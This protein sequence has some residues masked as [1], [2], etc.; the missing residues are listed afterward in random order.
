VTS[1]EDRHL[2]A[3]VEARD[4]PPRPAQDDDEGHERSIARGSAV[5]WGG[6]CLF[7]QLHPAVDRNHLGMTS[8]NNHRY[9]K[10]F[11]GNFWG[12]PRPPAAIR[13]LARSPKSAP[14]WRSAAVCGL[15]AFGGAG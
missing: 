2:R 10:P 8:E 3:E 13:A 4:Q 1:E 9:P 14:K 12:N 7:G 5:R 11:L 6:R 15:G